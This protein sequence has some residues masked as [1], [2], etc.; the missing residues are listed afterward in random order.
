MRL[1]EFLLG[2]GGGGG[3]Y[4]TFIKSSTYLTVVH[5][6]FISGQTF[7]RGEGVGMGAGGLNANF[8][9]NP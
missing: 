4:P 9:R 6:W 5:Q 7:S 8:Y 2:G 1:Q 3:P